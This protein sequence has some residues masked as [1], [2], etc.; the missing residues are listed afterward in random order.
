MSGLLAENIAKLRKKKKYTQEDL[1]QKLNVSFQ[2]VS[3]WENG[4]SSPDISLLP[5]LAYALDTDINSLIGFLYDKKKITIYEDE[6]KKDSYYWGIKPS[7]LCYR[8]LEMFPPIRPVKLLDIGCGEGKDSVFLLKTVI[9]SHRLI[10]LMPGLKRQ[11][12]LQN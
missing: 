2:A 5:D 4:Q 7:Y 10:S 9:L 12:V 11:N 8:I 6:Y 3:K 1:A